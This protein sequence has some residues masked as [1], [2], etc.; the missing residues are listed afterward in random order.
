MCGQG[1]TP[2]Y[3]GIR[4]GPLEGT[5]AAFFGLKT[6]RGWRGLDEQMTSTTLVAILS[7]LQWTC[8]AVSKRD[9]G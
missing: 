4:Y 2:T 6:T 8:C 1:P 3:I 5:A 7:L 9:P